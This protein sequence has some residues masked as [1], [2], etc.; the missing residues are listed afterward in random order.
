MEGELASPWMASPVQRSLLRRRWA[1]SSL[2]AVSLLQA[3][4][5]EWWVVFALQASRPAIEIL[6][7]VESALVERALVEEAGPQTPD[8]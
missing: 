5:P 3:L 4:P 6:A 8:R 2:Q 1:V 7:S